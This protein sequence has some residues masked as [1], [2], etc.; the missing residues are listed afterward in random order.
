MILKRSDLNGNNIEIQLKTRFVDKIKESIKNNDFEISDRSK[1]KIF[2]RRFRLN[3]SS[4]KEI[5]LSLDYSS[6][7][8]ID[9]DRNKENFGESP[10][11]ILITNKELVNFHGEIENIKIY[12]KLKL[13]EDMVIPVISFHEA[14]F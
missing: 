8:K 1:N 6:F 14:E 12:I 10:V 11:V 3:H 5:L 13:I 4:I 2:M 7:Y 9:E